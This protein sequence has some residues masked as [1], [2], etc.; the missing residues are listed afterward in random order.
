MAPFSASHGP[1]D[2]RQLLDSVDDVME[3][4]AFRRRSSAAE[5]VA[6]LTSDLKSSGNKEKTEVEQMPK[7]A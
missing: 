3:T 2:S 5:N 6:L 1:L 4:K 7:F